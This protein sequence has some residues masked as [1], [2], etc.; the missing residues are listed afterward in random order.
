MCTIKMYKT[1]ISNHETRSTSS[2]IR[3]AGVD[4][5]VVNWFKDY[6]SNRVQRLTINSTLST[7]GNIKADV[8]QGFFSGPLLFLIYI[9]NIVS[10]I[11]C[12]IKLFADDTTLCIV[13]G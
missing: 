7:W 2:N 1:I 6:L 13:C 5:H 9:G 3:A 8:P 10:R 12:T 4:G 11:N